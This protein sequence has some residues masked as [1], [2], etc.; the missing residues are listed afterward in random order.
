MIIR[1]FKCVPQSYAGYEIRGFITHKT[2]S[3]SFIEA[4]FSRN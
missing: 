2:Q 4:S 3:H 1:A